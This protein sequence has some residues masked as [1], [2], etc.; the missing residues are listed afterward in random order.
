MGL[1][2]TRRTM[3]A[4]SAGLMLPRWTWAES[5]GTLALHWKLEETG[6]SALESVGG[7]M[8]AIA[9][10]TG[11]AIWVGKGDSRALRLD[12]YSV[13]IDQPANALPLSTGRLTVCA[14]VALES[15]PVNDAAILHLQSNPQAEA[16]LLIDR[17]GTVHFDLKQGSGQGVYGAAHVE[18]TEP[19]AKGVW[20]HVAASVGD[21]GIRLY[22]DGVPCNAAQPSPRSGFGGAPGFAKEAVVTL[23]KSPECPVTA[24]V[25]PTGV[26]NGLLRDV[27]V[28]DAELSES[29]IA[30]LARASRPATAPDLQINGP[31]CVDDPQ[32]P[33]YHALPPRAWTNEPHGLVHFR[34]EYHLF[35]QKN[36]NGPYWGHIHWGHMTSPDLHR[37]TEMPVALAPGPGVDAD[38][39]WSGSA[40]EFEGKLALI[41]TAGDGKRSTICLAMSEDGVDFKKHAAN[42]IIAAVPPGHDFTEFRDPHV[43]REGDTYYLIIGSAVRDVGGTA[44]LYKSHDLVNWRYL[45]PLLVGDHE[46]SGVFWEM[47]IFVKLGDQ[48][49]L[50]VC[51]VPGRASYWVGTWKDETFTPRSL[52]PQ[53]LELLNHMLSPTPCRSDDGTV[54]TMGILPDQRS[55]KEDWRAGWA[56]LY[57]LPR[58]VTAD[59]RGRL[60]QT[61]HPVV[62]GWFEPMRSEAAI[63]LDDGVMM[64]LQASGVALNIRVVFKRMGSRRVTLRIRSSGDGQEHTD[65]HYEW[66]IGRLV[67][68][69]SHSSANHADRRQMVEE[70]TYFP[71]TSDR[72]EMQVLLDHS[73]LEVFLDKRAAFATIV[74]PMLETSTGVAVGCE[75]GAAEVE[76]LSVAKL[77]QQV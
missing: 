24:G 19:V 69:R 17:L 56:H 18:S 31:W 71:D 40:I 67:V 60:H 32:R 76:M 61:P 25:F 54:F 14:W 29:K 35:Y 63:K 64:P 5:Q 65:I 47:P 33:V 11:H 37:W 39:C 42:P 2:I 15:Y 22:I 13:W 53:R 74:H 26:L 45:K 68:D 20:V 21:S 73:V 10:R 59:E 27:R 6:D 38:G 58:V 7:T 77:R 9:S 44:L 28:Y 23:G 16:V 30:E 57:S 48:H 12:G 72:L 1:T 52:A 70:A 62:D 46:D 50:I 34:G 3:L 49:A 66:E 4:A 55:S 51:E 36:P 8:D 43:W 75:G 41:Y